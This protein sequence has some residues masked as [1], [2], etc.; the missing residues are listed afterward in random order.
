MTDIEV[1]IPAMLR[2]CAGD[3]TRFSVEAETLSGAL[4]RV[5]ASYPLLRTHLYD[6]A[7]RV[8]QHVL[9]FYNEESLARLERLDLPLR[10]GD[11]LTVLQNVSGG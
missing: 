5:F 2:D 7:G 6:E 8:R 1:S 11:R 3:C 10:P 9:I 4:E